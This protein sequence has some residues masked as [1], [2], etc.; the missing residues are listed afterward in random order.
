MRAVAIHDIR[1]A[2]GFAISCIIR[3]GL[4]PA[5][6]RARG[7]FDD[8]LSMALVALWDLNRCYRDRLP[9]Y[10]HDG[11]FSGYAARYLPARVRTA[12]LNSQA[13]VSMIS[14][15][16]KK[17]RVHFPA[18]LPLSAV[19]RDGDDDCDGLGDN[20]ASDRALAVCDP[21]NPLLDLH[22]MPAPLIPTTTTADRLAGSIL[23]VGVQHSILRALAGPL[24]SEAHFTVRVA[25][26]RA[27]DLDR[28]Q[29]GRRLGAGDVEVEMAIRRLNTIREEL[30][31]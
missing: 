21:P 28:A 29:I 3:A 7:D 16:G 27:L 20:F 24:A 4:E 10:E 23:P 6:L 25:E 19:N 26:L 17:R 31:S 13:N 12:Y 2:E 5:V 8:V 15:D 18:S 9:G 30:T 1:D 11:C 22:G 14:V